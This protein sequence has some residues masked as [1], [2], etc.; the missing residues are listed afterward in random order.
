M[1]F[2]FYDAKL[3]KNVTSY[4]KYLMKY[5]T[6][7]MGTRQGQG[8]QGLDVTVLADIKMITCAGEAP[9]QV[10]CRQVVLR[11]AAVAA[12]GGTMDDDKIDESHEN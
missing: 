8:T 12:G 11:I 7:D 3:I 5:P 6:P 4:L 10:V 9:A 1:L 2:D